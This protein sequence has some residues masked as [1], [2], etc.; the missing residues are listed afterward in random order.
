MRKLMSFGALHDTSLT[1]YDGLFRLGAGMQR[2]AFIAGLGGTLLGGTLL[3]GTLTWPL[4]ARAQRSAVPAIGFLRS[5]SFEAAPHMLDGFRSGLK[6]TGFVEG[7]NV[8]IEF[9]AADDR[10]GQLPAM[11]ADL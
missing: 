2:R 6:E 5:S 11:A 7:D 10:P 9:R 3:G 8:A 1:R 4:A